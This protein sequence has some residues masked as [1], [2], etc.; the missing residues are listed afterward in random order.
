MARVFSDSRTSS[1]L[2]LF[3]PRSFEPMSGESQDFPYLPHPHT[4][5]GSAQWGL[6]AMSLAARVPESL[7]SPYQYRIQCSVCFPHSPMPSGWGGGH[8]LTWK[9]PDL[10]G[11]NWGA[12]RESGNLLTL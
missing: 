1:W 9:F 7:S 11:T 10:G 5:C 12:C 2:T 6:K 8:S 3:L 4:V